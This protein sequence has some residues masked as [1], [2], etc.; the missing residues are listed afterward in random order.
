MTEIWYNK[1]LKWTRQTFN[2]KTGTVSNSFCFYDDTYL[3]S[4]IVFNYNIV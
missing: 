3:G 1:T 4:V 2:Y